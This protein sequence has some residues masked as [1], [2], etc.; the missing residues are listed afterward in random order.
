MNNDQMLKIANA[1]L[2]NKLDTLESRGAD[3]LDFHII[4]VWE[5]RLMLSKAFEAGYAR[6]KR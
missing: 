4:P 3:E 2:S 6:G 1:V 5:I